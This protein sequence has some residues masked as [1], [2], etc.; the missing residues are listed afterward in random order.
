ML[1]A[2]LIVLDHA[3]AECPLIDDFADVLE[4]EVA[5]REVLV[6][7]QPKAFLVGFDDCHVGVL[8]ALKTLILAISSAAAVAHTLH[9]GG[10]IDTVGV[11]AAGMISFFNRIC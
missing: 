5:R 7:S 11:L 2:L 6:G 10:T 9:L 8:F 1:D 3:A 4:Y